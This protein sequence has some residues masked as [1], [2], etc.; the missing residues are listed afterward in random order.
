MCQNGIGKSDVSSTS[1]PV[2]GKRPQFFRVSP[3]IRYDAVPLLRSAPVAVRFSATQNLRLEFIDSCENGHPSPF[4]R[5]DARSEI[6]TELCIGLAGES[7]SKE[8]LFRR[9]QTEYRLLI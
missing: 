7:R 3:D 8:S 6:G 5:L 2:P 9:T 1:L 4:D